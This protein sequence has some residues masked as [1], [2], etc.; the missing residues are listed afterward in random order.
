MTFF[1]YYVDLVFLISTL[2]EVAP[3]EFGTLLSVP[4]LD[5]PRERN[6]K[7]YLM[8]LSRGTSKS[9]TDKSLPNS[10]GVTSVRVEIRNTKST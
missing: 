2:T 9:G 5:V 6:I 4:D 7:Y 8:F 1:M 10:T 3:V